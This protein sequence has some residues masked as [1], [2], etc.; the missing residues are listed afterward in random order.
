MG[1]A[2]NG[3]VL[4]A[5]K[6]ASAEVEHFHIL[7]NGRHAVY[8]AYLLIFTSPISDEVTDVDRSTIFFGGFHNKAFPYTFC[9]LLGALCCSVYTE[10]FPL[11]TTKILWQP[12]LCVLKET[13]LIDQILPTSLN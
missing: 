13:I 12:S 11:T 7:L 2:G 8:T 3:C 1:E 4:V 6:T 10:A 5:F 9:L